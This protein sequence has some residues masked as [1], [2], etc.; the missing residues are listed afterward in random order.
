MNC[1]LHNQD[2][3][4]FYSIE[5]GQ[6][7]DKIEC[8]MANK[9]LYTQEEFEKICNQ[10]KERDYTYYDIWFLIHNLIDNHGFFY[11]KISASIN[12]FWWGDL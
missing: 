6:Y 9:H 8:I 3:I 1:D 4:Y 5:H 7:E 2:S 11:P 12:R 10:Y